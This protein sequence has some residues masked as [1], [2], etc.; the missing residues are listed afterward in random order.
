MVAGVAVFLRLLP[1]GYPVYVL[2]MFVCVCVFLCNGIAALRLMVAICCS[3]WNVPA[4]HACHAD[5]VLFWCV[6]LNRASW[7]SLSVDTLFFFMPLFLV[8]WP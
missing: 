3:R 4:G 6:S 7:V 1:T 5:V 8:W 2:P